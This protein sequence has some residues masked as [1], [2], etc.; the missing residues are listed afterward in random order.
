[1]TEMN[2]FDSKKCVIIN[3][4]I[5]KTVFISKNGKSAAKQLIK[6]YNISLLD[7]NNL[8]K[9]MNYTYLCHAHILFSLSKIIFAEVI[10]SRECLIPW[11]LYNQYHEV[12]KISLITDICYSIQYLHSNHVIHG[13]ISI[14]NIMINERTGHMY[15]VDPFQYLLLSKDIDFHNFDCLGHL[16]PEIIKCN[17]LNQK[18]IESEIWSLGCIIYEILTDIPPFSQNNIL[19]LYKNII[20]CNYQYYNSKSVEI[21]YLL[22]K[23]FQPKP[24]LRPNIN[25]ICKI[26]DKMKKIPCYSA[27]KSIIIN[28]DLSKICI[29]HFPSFPSHPINNKCHFIPSIQHLSNELKYYNSLIELKLLNCIDSKTLKYISNIFMYITTLQILSL[30]CIYIYCYIIYN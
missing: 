29:T 10:V 27:D 22:K 9:Y 23:I 19:S 4:S 18:S 24:E 28:S 21:D 26:L 12:D 20:K 25:E 6:I 14:N 16:S 8:I 5:N 3:K 1:M 15:L 11:K 13:N 30:E 7:K 17:I 2:N